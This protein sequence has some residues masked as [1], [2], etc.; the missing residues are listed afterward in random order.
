MKTYWMSG[1]P[2]LLTSALDGEEWSVSRPGSFILLEIA[3]ATHW[4]KGWVGPRVDLDA[5]ERRKI[6]PLPGIEPQRPARNPS[7]YRVSYLSLLA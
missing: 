4:I 2:P 6:L 5:V 1:A 7:L 3:T